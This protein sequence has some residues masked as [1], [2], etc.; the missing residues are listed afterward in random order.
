MLS[1]VPIPCFSNG[2]SVSETLGIEQCWPKSIHIVTM[3][4]KHTPDTLM[5]VEVLL[6]FEEICLESGKE[7]A[8]MFSKVLEVL[9]EKEILNE[10]EILSW[11]SEKQEAD[12]SDKVF[13]K[14]SEVFIQ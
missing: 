3:Q 11:E 13:L 2:I 8:P 5:E 12:E 10:E 6:K 7:F 14:Q 1:S 9:Y 4:E